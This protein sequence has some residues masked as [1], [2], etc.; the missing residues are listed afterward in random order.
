[1]KTYEDGDM[2]LTVNQGDIKYDAE[3]MSLFTNQ[4]IDDLEC[5]MGRA[6]I[7]E[8]N[9]IKYNNNRTFVGQMADTSKRFIIEV[10]GDDF[11]DNNIQIKKDF[12]TA[13][14]DIEDKFKSEVDSSPKARIGT[15][16]LLIIKND[17][18][19]Y[20]AVVD[21]DGYEIECRAQ[22]LVSDYGKW[23]I[24]T[25][26]CYR[27]AFQL[28]K[29]FCDTDGFLDNCILKLEDFDQ[30]SCDFLNNKDFIGAA[31]ALQTKINNAAGVLN[32]MT[33]YQPNMPKQSVSL[34][35]LSTAVGWN[36]FKFFFGSSD[37]TVVEKKTYTEAEYIQ[38]MKD[39][40]GFS[41]EDSKVIYEAYTKF[42]NSPSFSK[43]NNQGNRC[44]L[45]IQE[46]M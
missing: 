44:S 28:F 12:I 32:S 45:I 22:R 7:L 34:V 30:T 17:F 2:S 31:E 36:P 9:Y 27:K 23:G 18:G 39:Q 35:S 6:N 3:Q 46:M 33:V 15:K 43:V 40:Y 42:K 26:P 37:K 41:E 24:S 4:L 20:F 13:C 1:M 25:V 8:G 10:Q 29:D 11:H 5:F 21:A 16:V 38:S 14:F 19:A